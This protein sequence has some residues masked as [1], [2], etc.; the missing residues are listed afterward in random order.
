[1]RYHLGL[2]MGHVYSRPS[3]RRF[4]PPTDSDASQEPCIVEEFKDIS[5]SSEHA[6]PLVA[7]ESNVDNDGDDWGDDNDPNINNDE[8]EDLLEE[9]SD[10]S[11]VDEEELFAMEEMYRD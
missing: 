2:G 3:F 8:L 4:H 6:E 7:L 11:D 9:D 5:N 10:G 1:M